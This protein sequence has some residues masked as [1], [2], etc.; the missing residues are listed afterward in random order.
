MGGGFKAHI[1]LSSPAAVSDG[2]FLIRLYKVK[3]QFTAVRIADGGSSRNFKEQMGSAS[4][5]FLAALAGLPIGCPVYFFKLKMVKGALTVGGF[6]QDI[7]APAAITAVR[8][9]SGDE[10]FASE[11]DTSAS[12]VTGLDDDCGFIDE[13]HAA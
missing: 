4:P 13:F 3:Q 10:T 8:P 11:T 9:A 7:A 2:D 5:G 6:D 12:P 1:A